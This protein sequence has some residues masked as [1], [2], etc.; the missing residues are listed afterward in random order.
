MIRKPTY[1]LASLIEQNLIERLKEQ[2]FL[3][4]DINTTE[5]KK[6]NKADA[7]NDLKNSIKSELKKINDSSE[8]IEGSSCLTRADL[9][10]IELN[11][12]SPS[13]KNL[14]NKGSRFTHTEKLQF[15]KVK[16][17]YFYQFILELLLK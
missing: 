6:K 14:L 5:T 16:Y 12:L 2:A 7:L 11:L 4:Q 1:V 9:A 15:T 13:N 17:H 10:E 8:S 3:R